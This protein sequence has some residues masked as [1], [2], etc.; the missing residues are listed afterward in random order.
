MKELL[1]ITYFLFCT[2]PNNLKELMVNK[3]GQIKAATFVESCSV[4]NGYIVESGTHNELLA[5]RSA[6]HTYWTHQSNG[7][8]KS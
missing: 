2:I 3:A 6:Y 7:F 4:F 1:K 5:M 8:I